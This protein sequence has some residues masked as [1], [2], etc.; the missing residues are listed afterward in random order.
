[1]AAQ[2]DFEEIWDRR[3]S[4][5]LKWDS[6]ADPEVVPMWIADMDF[7]TAPAI[8]A[9]LVKKAAEGIFGY[10][11]IPA[12][13]YDVISNWWKKQYNLGIEKEWIIPAA[14]T[15]N[16]ITACQMDIKIGGLSF[17]VLEQALLQAKEG[18]LHI[19]QIMKSA[20][21]TP[22]ADL[23]PHAPRAHVIIIEREFIGAVIGP[24][25]KIVQEIQRESGATI[26]IEEKDNKGY[27]SI[28]AKDAKAMA[29]ARSRVEGIVAVPEVGTEY[30]ATVK[31][32]QPFGAFVE[33][34]PGK[35]GLLHIS[36]I[37]WERLPTMD[38]VLEIGEEI[39]VKLIE[40]D[41]KSG[42]YRLSR[43]V[44]LPRPPRQEKAAE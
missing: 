5:S 14:G 38:G 4:G 12:E 36:E 25:G 20:L 24:G 44:L 22:R 28:F 33:F 7:K 11:C 32:I 19:L 39:Q 9:A 23:K 26:T 27:V 18:R 1:M 40:I 15:E 29:M 21:E 8:T 35:E 41:K 3:G 2:F 10:P 31:S 30:Q 42:K 6:A 34:L 13:F 17:E 16:G 43:K 37:S